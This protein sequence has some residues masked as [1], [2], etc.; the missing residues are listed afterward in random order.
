MNGG[1]KWRQI[2]KTLNNHKKIMFCSNRKIF[3]QKFPFKC[4]FSDKEIKF[5][6]LWVI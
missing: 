6:R 1:P 4:V 3:S 5:F 2:S